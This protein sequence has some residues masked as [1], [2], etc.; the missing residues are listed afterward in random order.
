M[1]QI[2]LNKVY[3]LDMSASTPIE[4][5]TKK[6]TDRGVMCEYQNSWYGRTEIIDYRI[7]DMNGYSYDKKNF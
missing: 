3:R 7:F 4:V 5:K 6:F 1:K 2:V